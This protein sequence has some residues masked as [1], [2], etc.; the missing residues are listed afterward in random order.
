MKRIKKGPGYELVS[1]TGRRII[2]EII[3]KTRIE[4]KRVLLVRVDL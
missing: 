3:A 4:G 1:P 2:A